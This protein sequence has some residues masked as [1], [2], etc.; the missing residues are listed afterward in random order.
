MS[1]I[2]AF[3]Q[4]CSA[5][6]DKEFHQDCTKLSNPCQYPDYEPAAPYSI[7]LRHYDKANPPALVLHISIRPEGFWGAAIV[8][9]G[10]KLGSDFPKETV[11]HALI[12][13][14]KEAARK[15]SPG[16]E[17]QLHYGT[18]VW[19]LKGRYELN[20]QSNT[21]FVQSVLPELHNGLLSTYRVKY[22]LSNTSVVRHAD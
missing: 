2:L 6:S 9:L 12:F 7:E 20:R 14:D 10:C 3:S 11:I 18:Y 15:L 21:Q 4:L 16:F 5:Q 8:R 22:L 19:H 13:D 17:D 1:V